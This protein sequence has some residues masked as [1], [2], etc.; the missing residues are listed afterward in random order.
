VTGVCTLEPSLKIGEN[1]FASGDVINCFRSLLRSTAVIIGSGLRGMKSRI[2]NF[3]DRLFRMEGINGGY[4]WRLA[5][6]GWLGVYLHHFVC[7]DWLGDMHDHPYRL[8]SIG[9]LG[10]YREETPSGARIYRSPW[11]RS[12]PASHI[13]RI[14]VDGGSCWTIMITLK[15]VRTWGF[16]TSAGWTP[17]DKYVNAD[18]TRKNCP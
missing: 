1:D 12:F 18:L 9:L 15:P 10:K 6:I 2:S 17:C 4:R 5:R 14:M 11:L 13:H 7:N 3:I 16:W 8:V